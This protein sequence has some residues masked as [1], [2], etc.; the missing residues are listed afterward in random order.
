VETFW[1]RLNLMRHGYLFLLCGNFVPAFT[2]ATIWGRGLRTRELVFFGEDLLGAGKIL[3][4]E[5]SL[6][7]SSTAR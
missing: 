1:N 7:S 2:S 5:S 3:I 6:S 4:E